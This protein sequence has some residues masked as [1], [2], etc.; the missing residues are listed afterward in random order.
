M[1]QWYRIYQMPLVWNITLMC[2][3]IVTT[4]FYGLVSNQ[5][6]GAAL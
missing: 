6:V 2:T 5:T 1:L 4:L 3:M